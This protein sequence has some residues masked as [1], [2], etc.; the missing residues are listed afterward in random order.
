M[1]S[2]FAIAALFAA[3]GINAAPAAA[4]TVASVP[5]SI[6]ESASCGTG[7]TAAETANIPTDGSCFPIS[8]I[9]TGPTD[10]GII[11]SGLPAGCSGMCFLSSCSSVKGRLWTLILWF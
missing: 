11:L 3:V 9:R 1:H 6:F 2:T 4:A 7:P 5:L 8:F 10:A